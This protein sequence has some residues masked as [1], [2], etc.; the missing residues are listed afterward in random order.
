MS[1]REKDFMSF[2]RHGIG[3]RIA[4]ADKQIAV[5]AD[6]KE[7]D[8][9]KIVADLGKIGIVITQMDDQID[10]ADIRADDLRHRFGFAM[11][12]GKNKNF[13]GI[14]LFLFLYLKNAQEVIF[15]K[16]GIY[17]SKRT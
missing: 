9:R 4:A 12:I 7:S 10:L 15:R 8:L 17:C 5:A 16:N 1:V 14:R 13:H 3:N 6:A 11:C 2:E